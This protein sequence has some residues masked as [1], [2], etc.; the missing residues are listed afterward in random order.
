MNP[1]SPGATPLFPVPALFFVSLSTSGDLPSTY[2]PPST[3]CGLNRA[4]KIRR[5]LFHANAIGTLFLCYRRCNHYRYTITLVTLIDYIAII[6]NPNE[7]FVTISSLCYFL[8]YF[9][10]CL[11]F[12]KEN[13]MYTCI[14]TY[15][16]QRDDDYTN[17]LLLIILSC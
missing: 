11:F 12:L 13:L 1:L 10:L 2:V 7:C 3:R 4:R 17:S 14:Y 9:K 5:V 16:I 6:I 15:S 8:L